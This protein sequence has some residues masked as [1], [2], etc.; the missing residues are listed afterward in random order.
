[1]LFYVDRARAFLSL[2]KTD[3]A[4]ADAK[5][6]VELASAENKLPCQR[7]RVQV[8][9]E[10]GRYADAIAECQALLAEYTQPKEVRDIRYLLSSVYT[11]AKNYAKA[12]EQLQLILQADRD[13]VTAH[14]DLGYL[15]ADQG[16]NL[17][18]A[19]KL[20]RRALELDRSQ[21]RTGTQVD[22]DSDQ[23]HAAYVDSLGWVLFRRGQLQVARQELEKAT[24]LP[25]GDDPV[26]WDHLGDVYLQLEE[27]A[28]ARKAWQKAVELFEAGR[29]RPS[30][31]R[32]KEIKQKLKHLK[33]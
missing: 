8:L 1:V 5:A 27:P 26:I 11:G 25:E 13:D 21:R 29:R 30:D 18:E 10:A 16:K 20:I 14:N 4:L 6:A 24:A 33:P 32:Y 7:L 12:E 19:E 28:R 2:G 17:E 31:D 9:A 15:W 3:E 22:A 23:D